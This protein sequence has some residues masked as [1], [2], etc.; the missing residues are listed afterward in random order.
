[1]HLD[2][3]TAF[4]NGELKE[5]IYM[6]QP[7]SFS[8][9]EQ[10]KMCLLKRSIYGLKQSARL[11]NQ[12]IHDTPISIR[13]NQSKNDHCLYT[14]ADNNGVIYVLIYVDDVI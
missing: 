3:K 4:L 6:K 9:N 11:W 8:R 12:T 14:M 7:S 5:V 13:L 2:A 1:M 10:E